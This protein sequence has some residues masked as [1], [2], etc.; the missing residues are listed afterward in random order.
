MERVEIKQIA[1]Y[2]KDLEEGLDEWDYRGPAT[3]GD[4]NRLY[5]LI[6]H[7]MKATYETDDQKLKP[8]LAAL[9]YKARRCKECIE[10]RLAVRN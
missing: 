6:T 7:L 1:A 2:L 5:V 9:E 10:A 8:L 3:L 4:L